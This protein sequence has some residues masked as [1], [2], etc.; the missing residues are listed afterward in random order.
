MAEKHGPLGL[1]HFDSHSDTWDKYFGHR[2][3]H[4]TP[5]RR[6]YEEKLIDPERTVQVGIRGGV[7]QVKD[8]DLPRTLGFEVI[9]TRELLLSGPKQIAERIG[10][11]LGSGKTYVSFDIDVL[12]PAFAPGTGTP[13]VGG[14][15]TFQIMEVIRALPE[16]D[17][18]GLDLVEVLPDLD[19]GQITSL[20]AA[21]IIFEFLSLIASQR[22]K[23]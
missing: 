1:L 2:H 14:P 23:N 17:I 3:F 22:P 21:G 10:T 7:Y 5:F 8:R 9:S 12:D 13:E 16:I 15:S 18:V 19:T 4:G 11:R 20:A 6:A